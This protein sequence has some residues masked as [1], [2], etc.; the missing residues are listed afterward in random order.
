M[1]YARSPREFQEN[2]TILKGNRRGQ[3]PAIVRRKAQFDTF[4]PSWHRHCPD[5]RMCSVGVRG[6][7]GKCHADRS[8][9][10]GRDSGR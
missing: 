10:R 8:R 9:A 6:L 5:N 7:D 1:H 3:S 4:T 2:R